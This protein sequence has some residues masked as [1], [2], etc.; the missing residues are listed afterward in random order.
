M[1]FAMRSLAASLPRLCCFSRA[2]APPPSFT[3]SAF[4]FRILNKFLRLSSYL[5]K[6]FSDVIF[7]AG[8][9]IVQKGYA[10]VKQIIGKESMQTQWSIGGIILN[11]LGWS[12]VFKPCT[13]GLPLQQFSGDDHLLYFRRSLADRNEF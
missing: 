5:L 6:A 10:Q 4:A 1:S 8:S 11:L 9:G 3:D 12:F 7:L 13:Q 2:F